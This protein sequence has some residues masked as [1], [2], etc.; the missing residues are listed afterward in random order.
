MAA[1]AVWNRLDVQDQYSDITSREA[2]N[3]GD[4]QEIVEYEWS[5]GEARQKSIPLQR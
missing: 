3:I 5:V 1:V 4:T 2:H